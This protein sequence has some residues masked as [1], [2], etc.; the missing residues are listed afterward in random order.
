MFHPYLLAAPVLGI[1]WLF[2]LAVQR[3]RRH[4]INHLPGPPQGS[5]L[6][7]NVPD[8]NRPEQM[9]DAEF[10]WVKEHGT[11]LHIKHTFGTDRLWTADPKAMQYIMNTAGY[12]FPKPNETR[13]G[14]E[15]LLGR[16]LVWA[17][18]SQHSRQ[19][20]IMNPAFSFAALRG[21]VP[22]FR[23]T[24]QRA[25]NKIKDDIFLK[26]ESSVVNIMQWLS[27]TTLDAVGEAAFGYQFHAI[28]K[29]NDS[30]LANAYQDLFTESFLDR[31]DISFAVETILGYLPSWFTYLIVRL[32]IGRFKRI[33]D[34]ITVAIEV[35]Q[36]IVDKQTSL[37]LDGKEGSKDVMSILVRAN[38]SEDPK[39]KLSAEEILPQMTT[40][41]LAGHD[42]TAVTAAW[43]LYQLSLHREYQTLIR[44]EIA[45]TRAAAA[46]RGDSD[47]TIAD[48]DS[49]KYLLAAMKETL[50]YHPIA[51]GL[52]REAA[53]DDVIP[54]STPQKTKTGEMVTSVPI[55][56]GQQVTISFLAYNRLPEVWGPDAD[57][58]RPERFLEGGAGSQKTSL[59]V[60][61]NIATF[62]SG[63]R[64]CIGWR[65]A[66][67]EMQAILVEFLENF[68]F[69]PPPGNVEI[70]MGPA[71]IMAPMVKD[72]K[73]RKAELP[74]TMTAL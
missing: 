3:L 9:G 68:E 69:S 27:L 37:Y 44:E 12:N 19:R 49:M 67:L 73:E 55:S 17:E 34:Y 66:L 53:R 52:F 46:E 43:A 59:G 63:L 56:K 38:L 29:G 58:W 57:Q 64:S 22:L 74:I 35:A 31:P 10:A 39:S 36:E 4:S 48:L 40:L 16:G 54:L 25:V 28:D 23:Q 1:L 26:S 21:F 8:L 30:Y 7:G 60:I 14:V 5:W 41:F 13:V 47:L 6:V 33:H 20:K 15:M 61:A 51:V 45:A 32:P 71:G 62:S 50:R 42:T 2:R 24:A 70:F 11:T 65:F 18:G 72:A